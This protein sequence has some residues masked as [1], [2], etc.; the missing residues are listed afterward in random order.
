ML[1]ARRLK[2]KRVKGK[3][4]VL[5]RRNDRSES[6]TPWMQFQRK[7]RTLTHH[8]PDLSKP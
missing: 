3:V 7:T 6:K 5:K 4:Q 1:K 8:S 2:M